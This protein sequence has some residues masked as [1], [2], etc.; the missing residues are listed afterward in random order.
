MTSISAFFSRTPALTSRQGSGTCVRPYDGHAASP[1]IP[2][3]LGNFPYLGIINFVDN[4]SRSNYNSL[5]ATLTKRLSHGLEFTAGYTYGHGLDTGSVNFQ[6]LPP[7]Q[8]DIAK[9]VRQQRLRRPA[10]PDRHGQ[11]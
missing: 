3:S 7:G 10:P 9:G 1:G 6:G 4:E 8:H 11:L 5:Q 2:A